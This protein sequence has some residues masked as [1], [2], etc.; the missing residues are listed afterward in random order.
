MKIATPARH[1]L[2]EA[3]TLEPP[4]AMEGPCGDRNARWGYGA[5]EPQGCGVKSLE[6]FQPWKGH[7]G[8][9]TPHG[10]IVRGRHN[11]PRAD[12]PESLAMEGQGG[13]RDVMWGYGRAEAQPHE[14]HMHLSLS[15]R[16]RAV[17][18]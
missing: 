8:I 2:S 11:L 1:N 7:V 12:K 3:D 5:S 9:G 13:N 17:W 10:D 18:G 16:G 14:G 6:S 15:G 4:P